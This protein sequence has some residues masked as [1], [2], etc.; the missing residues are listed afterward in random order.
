MQQRRLV[1][2]GNALEG[3]VRLDRDKTLKNLS[4]LM[5][6]LGGVIYYRDL[7][8]LIVL[9]LVAYLTMYVGV[10]AYL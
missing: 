2:D 3:T 8:S 6:G 7:S 10:V 9:G 4:C 5:I 1:R